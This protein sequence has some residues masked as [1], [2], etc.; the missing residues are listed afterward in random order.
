MQLQ[1]LLDHLG[2]EILQDRPAIVSGGSGNLWSDTVL[3]R[4]LNQAQQ[5][6]ARRTYCL[7]DATTTAATQI[8]LV[9]ATGVYALHKSV[10]KVLS[11]RLSDSTV[12]LYAGS[13]NLFQPVVV[14]TFAQTNT[15]GRPSMWAPDEEYRKLRVF[16]AP[17]TASAALTLRLRVVRGPVADLTL[18]ALTAEPE[19]PEE[20]HLD[21]C[22]WAAY[23]ALS[24]QE[25]DGE[26]VAAAKGFKDSFMETIRVARRGAQILTDAPTTYQ[27]GGWAN[28]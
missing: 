1:E 8:T 28:D 9:A 23:R 20:Y 6:F 12:D 13:R 10:L 15:P 14:D 27:F 2:T 18:N 25:V 11:V 26:A 5:L 24:Q 19:I 16:P 7:L 3:I 21:L 22:D 4:Y 17:D